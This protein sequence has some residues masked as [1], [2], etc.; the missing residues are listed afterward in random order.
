MART[1]IVNN[2][3]YSY[4]DPGDDP[5]WGEGA[6]GWAQAVTDVLNTLLGAADILETTATILANAPTPVAVNGLLFN[7]AI[8]RAGV[9]DYAI[10]R[11]SDEAPTGFLEEGYISFL[12]DPSAGPGDRF[13]LTRQ[14]TGDSLVEFEI[15]E[16][17]G[18]VS[19]TSELLTPGITNY[20]GE[21][22]FKARAILS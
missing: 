11:T 5:G 10:T 8:V 15:D 6:T 12:Y 13:K 16:T 9:I 7:P 14:A 1:L 22:K 3:S 19:Y 2:T 18:Q 17:T 21:I 20:F 4:P